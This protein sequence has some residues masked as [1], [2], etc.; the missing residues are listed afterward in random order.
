[1]EKDIVFGS[2]NTDFSPVS[3]TSNLSCYFGK[4]N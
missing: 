1:M 2:Q 4:A 3:D